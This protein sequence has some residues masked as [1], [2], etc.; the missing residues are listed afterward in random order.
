MIGPRNYHYKP[1]KNGN[2]CGDVSTF[3]MNPK[4]ATTGRRFLF[5][6]AG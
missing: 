4:L 6:G 1:K 2:Q 3:T 5:R